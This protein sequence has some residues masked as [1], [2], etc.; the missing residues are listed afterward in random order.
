MVLQ[1]SSLL[2]KEK[3]SSANIVPEPSLPTLQDREERPALVSCKR[4]M[5]LHDNARPHTAR[6]TEKKILDLK[7]SVLPHP[8]YSPDLVPTDY[9]L[10]RSLQNS[11]SGKKLNNNN[12]VREYIDTFIASNDPDFFAS[13]IDKLPNK[14]EKVIFNNEDYI[15]D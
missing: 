5:L 9:H 1:H 11:L 15:L 10:F 14:Y 3:R 13:G 8:P 6:I 2:S 12:K 4:V 7:W